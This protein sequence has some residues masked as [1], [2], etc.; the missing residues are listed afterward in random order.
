MKRDSLTPR[1]M[2]LRTRLKIRKMTQKKLEL[3]ENQKI[4]AN[5]IIRAISRPNAKLLIA[6][7]SGTKYIHVDD[8]F[9]KMDYDGVSIINGR[10]SYDLTLPASEMAL[11]LRRFNIRLEKT[12]EEWDSIIS[13]K[14]NHSLATIFDDMKTSK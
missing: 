7:I 11:L 9:I 13:S 6:P 1:M 3:E 5:I 10:Y 12:R 8:I 4:A 14:T 2:Y